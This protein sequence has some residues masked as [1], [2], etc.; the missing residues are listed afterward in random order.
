[1]SI[2]EFFHKLSIFKTQCFIL[3]LFICIKYFL[4]DLDDAAIVRQKIALTFDWVPLEYYIAWIASQNVNDGIIH[5]CY[6]LRDA[7]NVER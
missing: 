2:M 5:D 1:M 7:S 4:S 3:Y 6:V